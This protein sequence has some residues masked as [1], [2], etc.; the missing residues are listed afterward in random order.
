MLICKKY[1]QIFDL[2]CQVSQNRDFLI[3]HYNRT[4]KVWIIL[5]D[6]YVHVN[7]KKSSDSR[8]FFN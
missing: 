8:P 6:G 5:F 1:S 3:V 4:C 2:Y 7:R